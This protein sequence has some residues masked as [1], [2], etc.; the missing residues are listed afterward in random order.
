MAAVGIGDSGKDKRRDDN[1]D[2]RGSR[3][4]RDYDDYY[5]SRDAP[6][7]QG[8]LRGGGG[9]GGDGIRNSSSSRSSSSSDLGD[10]S[11][12]EE[13][14]IQRK[15]HGKEL[16]T[17]GLAGVATIHAAHSVYKSVE[18]RKKRSK[19]VREGEMS[20]EKARS[21]KNKARLQDAAAVGIAAL[22]IKSAVGEWKEMKE[23]R[24]EYHEFE[25]KRAL[26]HERRIRKL[27]E[28][29]YANGYRQRQSDFA[30]AQA[31]PQYHDDNPYSPSSVSSPPPPPM[32]SQQTRYH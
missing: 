28:Q 9:E 2:P 16:L 12:S 32:G 4:N 21:L 11:S 23:Q 17:T 14:R 20:P 30:L 3:R 31:G 8:R 25:H 15:L 24:H 1:R 19:L 5:S 6:P 10:I 29:A 18:N 27:E 7:Q 13:D 22:G 26:R